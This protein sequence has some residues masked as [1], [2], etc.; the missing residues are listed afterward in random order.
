M[1]M[2]GKSKGGLSSKTYL[3]NFTFF[4]FHFIKTLMREKAG[5]S[6]NTYLSKIDP[7][8][9]LSLHLLLIRCTP[10]QNYFSFTKK[11]WNKAAPKK[12][13]HFCKISL[14]VQQPGVCAEL[15]PNLITSQSP[16]KAASH[17]CRPALKSMNI[18]TL[19]PSFKFYRVWCEVNGKNNYN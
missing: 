5:L 17:Q 12:C 2:I 18:W 11:N 1:A 6:A 15:I 8:L 14:N 4:Y 19:P 3:P 10:V 13:P 7:R 9:L 16:Q